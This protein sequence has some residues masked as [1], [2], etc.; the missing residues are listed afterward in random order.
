MRIPLAR[1]S[2]SRSDER[3]SLVTLDQVAEHGGVPAPSEKSGSRPDSSVGPPGTAGI[4]WRSN[5]GSA[6]C[7]DWRDLRASSKRSL[8]RL[9]ISGTI[10]TNQPVNATSARP[11]ATS[12]GTMPKA[13]RKPK[14]IPMRPKND[15]ICGITSRRYRRAFFLNSSWSSDTLRAARS[16]FAIRPHKLPEASEPVYGLRAIC[17]ACIR[18]AYVGVDPHARTAAVYKTDA[19]RSG[20]RPSE[21]NLTATLTA[22]GSKTGRFGAVE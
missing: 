20:F 5:E 10:G 9:N 13:A 21:I 4:Y 15:T 6:Y 8:F 16:R 12:A 18:T 22:T 2:G 11:M 14:P 1:Q 3:R 19:L 7:L 17:R